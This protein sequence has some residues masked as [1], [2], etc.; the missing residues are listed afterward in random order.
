MATM[1]ERMGAAESWIKRADIDLYGRNGD[2]G[3]VREFR[4]GRAEHTGRMKLLGVF[5]IIGGILS[6]AEIILGFLRDL[7]VLR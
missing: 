5:G 2:L 4:E 1:E 6:G 7:H 3:I